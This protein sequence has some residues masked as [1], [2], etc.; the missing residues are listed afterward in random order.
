MEQVKCSSCGATQEIEKDQDCN[1][2]GTPIKFKAA[3]KL[4]NDTLKGDLG[5]FLIMAETALDGDD[6]KEAINYYNKILEKEINYADA[7]LGKANA[8]IYTSKIGDIKMK[9]A[10]TYWKNSVKFSKNKDS[11]K[12]RVGKEINSVINSFF[13]NIL[14]H[15]KEF[16]SLDNSFQELATRFIQLE[17]GIN[18]ACDICPDEADFFQTGKNLCEQVTG[19]P[20]IYASGQQGA[21]V[22]GALIGAISGNKYDQRR[23]G[24]AFASASARKAQIKKYSE[25]IS[26]LKAKYVEGLVRLGVISEEDKAKEIASSA[27]S[28]AKPVGPIDPSTIDPKEW[29]TLVKIYWGILIGCLAISLPTMMNEPGAGFFAFMVYFLLL[30]FLWLNRRCKKRLGYPFGDVWKIRKQIGK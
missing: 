7:W 30:Y 19:A 28:N 21:A 17:S 4:Y 23:A 15:Y 27:S 25:I 14:N 18:Y 9:E 20:S 6:Y 29:S 12:L 5:N 8:M 22:A 11:M 2:C 16:S 24:N 3:L 1:Y 26:P 13:P 10:L